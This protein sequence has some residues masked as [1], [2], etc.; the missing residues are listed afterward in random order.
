MFFFKKSAPATLSVGFYKELGDSLI[1]NLA[2]KAKSDV[3]GAV[4]EHPDTAIEMLELI[5][6]SADLLIS[7]FRG[8]GIQSPALDERITQANDLI[9]D[10]TRL[11]ASLRGC[12]PPEE[13]IQN[14]VEN[15]LAILVI[16]TDHGLRALQRATR[17]K[18]TT[19]ID[20]ALRGRASEVVAER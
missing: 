2:A 4:V 11:I 14:K 9:Q 1:Q 8:S 20:N 5:K 16:L 12:G 7:A 13:R 6:R 17:I 3:M 18:Y 15:M 10:C 19:M